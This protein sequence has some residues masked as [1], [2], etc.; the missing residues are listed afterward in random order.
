M[1]PESLEQLIFGLPVS[2]NNL[3]Q[4]HFSC[5]SKNNNNLLTT[6]LRSNCGCPGTAGRRFFLQRRVPWQWFSTGPTEQHGTLEEATHWPSTPSKWLKTLCTTLQLV[7][8]NW[9]RQ[10]KLA[11]YGF[12]SDESP[13]SLSCEGCSSRSTAAC[14]KESNLTQTGCF[15][16]HNLNDKQALNCHSQVT[17]CDLLSERPTYNE[18]VE[19][20]ENTFA[21]NC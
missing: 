10:E 11:S 9:F 1:I 21:I 12:K 8:P 6:A 16:W 18:V 20:T 17:R 5:R 13:G 15:F 4:T 3:V 7:W 2:Q 19:H 14:L